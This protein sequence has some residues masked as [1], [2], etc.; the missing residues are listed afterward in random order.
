MAN[1]TRRF[2]MS[3]AVLATSAA[4]AVPAL[5][6]GIQ[7]AASVSVEEALSRRRSI[8][9]FGGEDVS[10]DQ[11]A[12]L[13]WAAGGVNRQE[14]DGR[15]APSWH[16]ANDV[17]IFVARESGVGLY[18]PAAGS[19]T[20][21]LEED[22]L[23]AIS[24]QGFVARAPVVLLFV[25]RRARLTEAEGAS[26]A[27]DLSLAIAAHVNSAVMAQNV[28]LFCAAEGLATCV[29][30]G[31]DRTAI[32]SRLSLSEGDVVTYVQPVGHPR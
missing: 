24:P 5:G 16:T 25:S 27:D 18:D 21:A 7:G 2:F 20:A 3:S 8:R 23:G 6:Q 26:Q 14:N 9:H 4:A 22:I 32:A 11:L 12:R 31:I 30:G 1:V 29:V 13:L 28:Y 17:D 10:D 19:L 15:T